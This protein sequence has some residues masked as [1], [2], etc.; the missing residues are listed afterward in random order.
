M[1]G[2]MLGIRLCCYFIACA[3]FLQDTFVEC[4]DEF[5]VGMGFSSGR[6]PWAY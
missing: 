1:T 6:S 5:A 2:E 4:G 3:S